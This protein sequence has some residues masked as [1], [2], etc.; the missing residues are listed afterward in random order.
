MKKL[1]TTIAAFAL[2]TTLHFGAMA[3][4]VEEN[5]E[6]VIHTKKSSIFHRKDFGLYLGLNNYT[7][8][9]GLPE[10]NNLQS[11]F[12]AL[13]WRKNHRLVTGGQVDLAMATGWE[14]AWNNLMFKDDITLARFNDGTTDFVDAGRVLDK[15]KLTTF[16]LNVPLMLQVG[17]KESNWRMG[18]GAYGGVR[19]DSYTKTKDSENGTKRNHGAYNLNKFHYGLAAEMGRDGFMVFARYEMTP[20][21]RDGNRVNGNVISFGVRL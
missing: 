12:V 14:L 5:D 1:I 20:M 21:F 15:S 13:Q 6:R 16:N 8:T 9:Q 4:D 19:L 10:L 18:V 11:R 2:A 7:N 17:F 3:Q